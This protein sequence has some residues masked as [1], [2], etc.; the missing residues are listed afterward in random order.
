LVNPVVTQASLDFELNRVYT[1]LSSRLSSLQ[2]IGTNTTNTG[3]NV[4]GGVIGTGIIHGGY[5]YGVEGAIGSLL[6]EGLGGAY[7]EDS[8]K[9][10]IK[11]EYGYGLKEGY[12]IPNYPDWDPAEWASRFNY[13]GEPFYPNDRINFHLFNQND[14]INSYPGGLTSGGLPVYRYA[15][16]QDYN[17]VNRITKLAGYDTVNNNS[18]TP[19]RI[20]GSLSFGIIKKTI[21][22]NTEYLGR[23]SGYHINAQFMNCQPAASL[24]SYDT[25]QISNQTPRV[26]PAG[27][28][29][30]SISKKDDEFTIFVC[31]PIQYE[32]PYAN[33]ESNKFASFAVIHKEFLS[34]SHR[35]RSGF[36]LGNEIGLCI[37]PTVQFQIIGIPKDFG[38][39]LRGP[40]TSTGNVTM[41]SLNPT[42]TLI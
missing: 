36:E 16:T 1:S 10:R 3:S 13:P 25:N 11:R 28:N 26:F 34:K 19:E 30:I 20:A 7:T 4:A 24:N 21:R 23:Y 32:R 17:A 31:F 35:G 39:D 22:L 12:Q 33:R 14:V 15:A 29:N 9:D 37:Y 27:M 18:N 38:G 2:P 41:N 6:I 40:L 5:F 42:I 8:V